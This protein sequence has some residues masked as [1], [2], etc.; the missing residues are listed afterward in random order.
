LF[1]IHYNLLKYFLFIL[2]NL[3]IHYMRK[4]R[5]HKGGNPT[6]VDCTKVPCPTQSGDGGSLMQITASGIAKQKTDAS[7]MTAANALARGGGK[8]KK[9]GAAKVICPQPAAG[10][11]G[12][13]SAGGASAG[14]NM[15][16][17]V[18]HTMQTQSNAQYDTAAKSLSTAP[19]KDP[20][21]GQSGG[22]PRRFRS[23][24]RRKKKIKRGRK[25]KRRRRRGK[26]RRRQKRT[27][28]KT[29]RKRRY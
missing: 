11:G 25:T 10:S 22:K 17:G 14:T 16:S 12:S 20:F 15:C 19:P 6:T 4:S 2:F 13:I 23:K 18:K 29:R 9:G 5:K 7:K 28:K 3:N 26:S 24:R 8:R 21:K 1:I 27:R